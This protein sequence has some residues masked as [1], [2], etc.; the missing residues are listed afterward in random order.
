MKDMREF[1]KIYLHPIM[2]DNEP[3][4]AFKEMCKAYEKE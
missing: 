1:Y 3:W 2:L 4:K